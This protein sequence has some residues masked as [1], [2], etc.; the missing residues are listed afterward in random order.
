MTVVCDD[1]GVLGLGGIIGGASSAV[2]EKTTNVYIECA[3]FDAALTAK[4][5]QNCK[6]IPMRVTV[7][8]AALIPLSRQRA[9]RLPHSLFL[10]LCGGEASEVFCGRRCA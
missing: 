2:D 4:T 6:S 10:D 5:G 8:S 1:S 9:W 3:Y 7:S